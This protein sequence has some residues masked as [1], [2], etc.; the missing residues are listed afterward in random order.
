M[1]AARENAC[2]AE[3]KSQRMHLVQAVSEFP[4]AD[5]NSEVFPTKVTT[6]LAGKNICIILQQ[7]RNLQKLFTIYGSN[8]LAALVIEPN[9]FLAALVIEPNNFLTS[10]VV[11]HSI[12]FP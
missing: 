4:A 12:P 1:V 7:Y 5:E 3:G 10:F 11:V 6:N 9:N 2:D 8:F